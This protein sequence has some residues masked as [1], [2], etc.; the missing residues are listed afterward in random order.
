MKEEHFANKWCT[1]L[2]RGTPRDLFDVYQIS[3]TKTDLEVFRKC[4]IVDSLM[5]GKPKLHEINVEETIGAI[6]IN[7][8]LRNVLQTEQLSKLDFNEIR[9]RT[10]KFSKKVMKS[11]TQNEIKAIE[12]FFQLKIFDPDLI[13][14]K[15]I[16]HE[17][18]QDHPAIQRALR[19]HV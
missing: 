9:E 19:T 15:M 1:L 11:L 4:S 8:N 17:K 7:S 13:D 5:R 6:H 10:A 12:R 18:V 16:F 2:Y 14:E 3:K